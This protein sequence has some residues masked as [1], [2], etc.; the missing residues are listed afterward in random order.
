MLEKGIPSIFLADCWR[1]NNFKCP[2]K[3]TRKT[4]G[5]LDGPKVRE[6]AVSAVVR[7]LLVDPQFS[8]VYEDGDVVRS[9]KCCPNINI[10]SI[11]RNILSSSSFT[12]YNKRCQQH[13]RLQSSS[14]HI[15]RIKTKLR[16]GTLCVIYT[17]LF[18]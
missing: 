11:L 5:D 15:C 16:L 1:L 7:G 4:A 10:C 13:F 8:T 18:E 6:G 12:F 3:A 2:D 17:I 14:G 9:D